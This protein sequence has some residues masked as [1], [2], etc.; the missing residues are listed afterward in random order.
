MQKY[1]HCKKNSSERPNCMA[2]C[3]LKPFLIIDDAPT[4]RRNPPQHEVG[5]Y[6]TNF[7]VSNDILLL[8]ILR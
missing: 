7:F 5:A 8:S 2:Y 4:K 6:C 3:M 1:R